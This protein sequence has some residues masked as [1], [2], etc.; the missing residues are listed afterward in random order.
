VISLTLTINAKNVEFI[1]DVT[2]YPTALRFLVEISVFLSCDLGALAPMFIPSSSD[3]S[4]NLIHA[5]DKSNF[6]HLKLKMKYKHIGSMCI[7]LR[8]TRSLI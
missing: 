3:L 4:D 7:F 8:E 5:A 6:N 2:H 1:R